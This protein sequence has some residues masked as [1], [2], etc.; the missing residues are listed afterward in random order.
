MIAIDT[1]VLLR[2]ILQDDKKQS[3]PASQL[4]ESSDKILIT[5]VVLIET[6]WTLS[7]K[8]YSASSHEI[9]TL[10]TQLL[11]EPNFI[12][13]NAQAIWVALNTYRDI[14]ETEQASR[15]IKLPDFPDALIIS[16]SKL[17]AKEMNEELESVYSFD[18]GALKIIGTSS[19]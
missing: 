10:V 13:E 2:H 3:F 4:I 1:N 16:K 19:P 11:S 5:D 17:I 8:R 14:H 7:G 12:F 6:V 18:K 9:V 15:K